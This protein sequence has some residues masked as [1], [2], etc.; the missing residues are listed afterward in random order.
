MNMV[1]T[2]YFTC[3]AQQTDLNSEYRCYTITIAL[4]MP[5][6]VGVW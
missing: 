6:P 5:A 3:D 1:N 4:S 2:A